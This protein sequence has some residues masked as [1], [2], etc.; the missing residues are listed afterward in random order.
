LRHSIAAVGAI[1]LMIISIL[2]KSLLFLTDFSANSTHAAEYGHHL[3]C[4]IDANI[5]LCNAINVSDQLRQSEF[6]A[7]PLE[8]EDISLDISNTE[9]MELKRHLEFSHTTGFNPK[10]KGINYSG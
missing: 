2:M 5:I 7:W 3:A 1:S 6:V 4:Q 9:V 10:I 8:G